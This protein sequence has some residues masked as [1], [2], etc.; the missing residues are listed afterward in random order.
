[1]NDGEKIKNALEIIE[2]MIELTEDD[3]SYVFVKIRHY[4]IFP[5]K[6]NK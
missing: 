1:M 6:L 5:Y 4:R 2:K 3:L